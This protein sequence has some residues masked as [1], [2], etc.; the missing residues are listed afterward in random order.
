MDKVVNAT[1]RI[2]TRCFMSTRWY[3][4]IVKEFHKQLIFFFCSRNF[5]LLCYT[6][7]LMLTRRFD[8]CKRRLEWGEGFLANRKTWQWNA[9][10][11]Y[12]RIHR[13][14]GDFERGDYFS[15]PTPSDAWGVFAA[16]K[17]TISTKRTN[18]LT[19]PAHVGEIGHFTLSDDAIF[20]STRTVR[21]TR[22]VELLFRKNIFSLALQTRAHVLFR[23]FDV[24]NILFDDSRSEKR[25]SVRSFSYTCTRNTNVRA[26]SVLPSEKTYS[27]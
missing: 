4:I 27:A 9:N 10:G 14:V 22:I 8:V 1:R 11:T 5:P 25:R 24:N 16:V 17:K 20:S 3:K 6:I 12:F 13:I 26:F 15:D 21:W 19:G 18:T 7:I 2:T 23:S